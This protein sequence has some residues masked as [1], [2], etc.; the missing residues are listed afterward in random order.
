MRANS[1]RV[2][3]AYYRATHMS[4]R[5]GALL[6]LEGNWV[7]EEQVDLWEVDY[8]FYKNRGFGVGVGLNKAANERLGWQVCAENNFD[9]FIFARLGFRRVWMGKAVDGVVA[10]FGVNVVKCVS[11][12]RRP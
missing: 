8:S 7:R 1:G 3:L 10:S 4:H 6:Q 2:S 11:E 12:L 5:G 9:G